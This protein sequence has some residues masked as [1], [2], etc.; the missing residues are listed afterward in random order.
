MWL[1]DR[2]E[3]LLVLVNRNRRLRDRWYRGYC[4][5]E[6]SYEVYSRRAA[7]LDTRFYAL[8]VAARR[9]RRRLRQLD[10]SERIPGGS[11]DNA[12]RN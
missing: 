3:R 10:H 1:Y 5:D 11:F 6:V 7:I 4:S 9:E 2:L 8:S 12:C